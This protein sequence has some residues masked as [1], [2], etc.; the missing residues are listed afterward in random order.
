M[1]AAGWTVCSMRVVAR[2]HTCDARTPLAGYRYLPKDFQRRT[3]IMG[4]VVDLGWDEECILGLFPPGRQARCHMWWVIGVIIYLCLLLLGLVFLY[5]ASKL[6]DVS[7]RSS[8][9]DDVSEIINHLVERTD[10]HQLVLPFSPPI[11]PSLRLAQLRLT[12]AL[13][14][15]F[16][17]HF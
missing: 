15:K 9:K 14:G 12:A 8:G 6:E 7:R 10:P 1:F 16:F 3:I 13:L 2:G 17:S 11:T 5:G 4:L